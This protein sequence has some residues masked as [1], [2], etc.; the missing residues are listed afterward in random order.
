MA[1]ELAVVLSSGSL[2]SVVTASLALQRYRI[3]LV[4]IEAGNASARSSTFDQ[5]VQHLKPFRAY[6]LPL[7][8]LS[9]ITR[10]D[11]APASA[12]LRSA[13]PRSSAGVAGRLIDLM[14]A[15]TLGIRVAV[16]HNA[17]RLFLGT[18]LGG[19]S[20]DL[21]R[22]V[23]YNQIWSELLALTCDKPDFD[24]ESPVLELAPWQVVDL[25]VQIGSPLQLSWSCHA[26]STD[27]CGKCAGCQ[28]RQLAFQR[29]AKPDPL[30]AA[31]ISR[32]QNPNPDEVPLSRTQAARLR[33]S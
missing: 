6:K 26:P 5:Q 13:D 7:P 9:T 17:N 1:K 20:N 24:I 33:A 23:E 11:A 16:H 3:I 22:V 10:T 28:S 30:A 27:P 8:F 12:D 21:A 32:K 15:V 29:A 2:A 4:H 31:P 18:R 25:G 14:P 19:D